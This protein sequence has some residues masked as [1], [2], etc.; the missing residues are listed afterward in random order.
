MNNKTVQI[1]YT[2]I[3]PKFF[4]IRCIY[5]FQCTEHCNR[6]IWNFL[7]NTSKK[8]CEKFIACFSI[9]FHCN[10]SKF[11]LCNT[12][13]IFRISC[14][15]CRIICVCRFRIRRI[16]QH[17][18]F[19]CRFS[20]GIFS[21][22]S[23]GDGGAKA[24]RNFLRKRVVDFSV[25]GDV[26]VQIVI[27]KSCGGTAGFC[28]FHYVHVRLIKRTHK[29][30][31]VIGMFCFKVSNSTA[32]IPHDVVA[33]PVFSE[34]PVQKFVGFFYNVKRREVCALKTALVRR[35]KAVAPFQKIVAVFGFR[36]TVVDCPEF[37][38]A[39]IVSK[40][41]QFAVKKKSRAV[42]P[43]QKFCR[44]VFV[45]TYCSVAHNVCKKKKAVIFRLYSAD[46]APDHF[47]PAVKNLL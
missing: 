17:Q 43:V 14:T 11:C 24:L 47:Y 45:R 34:R 32:H 12:C 36:R 42:V 41:V 16:Y 18:N 44:Q 46:F 23:F 22:F 19:F 31:A 3:F 10:R 2:Y 7:Y 40:F 30:V 33:L 20:G 13:F 8:L 9:F 6:Y 35:N 15:F 37:P 5:I 27:L 25:I 26:V 1:F 21:G 4:K 38:V 29:N 39:V 28:G